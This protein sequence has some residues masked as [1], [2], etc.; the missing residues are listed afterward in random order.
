MADRDDKRNIVS[1]RNRYK[2]IKYK[3]IAGMLEGLSDD[4]HLTEEGSESGD[5]PTYDPRM[6]LANVCDKDIACAA[7]TVG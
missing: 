5:D 3:D 1:V 7:V 2:T 4:G 6:D